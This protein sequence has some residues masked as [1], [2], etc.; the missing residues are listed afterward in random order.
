MLLESK[1]NDHK[2]EDVAL[3]EDRKEHCLRPR[4]DHESHVMN[5]RTFI[6][7][8]GLSLMVSLMTC[9][10][11]FA[12]GKGYD[13]E[14]MRLIYAVLHKIR[15]RYVDPTRVS[16]P[17]MLKEALSHI[18]RQVP[19][20]I[21]RDLGKGIVEIQVD[22]AR[23]KFDIGSVNS[24]WSLTDRLKKILAFIQKNLRAETKRKHVEY[25][26]VDGM[27]DT[28][29]PHSV[30]MRPEF[31]RHMQIS[32]SGHFGGLGIE[33]SICDGELTIRRPLKHTP[34]WKTRLKVGAEMVRAQ[35]MDEAAKLVVSSRGVHLVSLPSDHQS[36]MLKQGEQ[37]VRLMAGDKIVRIENE[38]TVNMTLNDAVNRLRGKPGTDVVIWIMRKGWKR[39][40]PF[41]IRRAEIKIP[42]VRSQMLSGSIAYVRLLKFQAETAMELLTTLGKMRSKTRLNGLIMDL[43]DNHG[44]L[45]DQAVHVADMFVD[46]GTLVS[47]VG[48]AGSQRRE[49]RARMHKSLRELSRLPMVVLVNG[50]S[51]SA[52]EIVAAALK[53]LDRA[54][55]LGKNTF[56]KG[57]VQVIFKTPSSTGLKLTISQ[58]FAPNNFSIQQVGLVPDIRTLPVR[59]EAGKP[60]KYFTVEKDLRRESDLKASLRSGAMV[61]K[62]KPYQTMHYL[63]EPVPPKA[64]GF[65]CRF[66]GQE[67]DD[68]PLP[69]PDVF[70]E[71]V[72]IRLAKGLLQASPK[73]RRTEMLKGAQGYFQGANGRQASIIAARFSK[74][75]IDWSAGTRPSARPKLETSCV[76]GRNGRVTSGERL[77]VTCKVSNN[78]P[79]PV[80]RLRAETTSSHPMLRNQEL[81][82]GAILPQQ[83]KQAAFSVRIPKSFPAQADTLTIKF[84]DG[85]GHAPAPLTMMVYMD[86]LESPRFAYSYKLVEGA[87]SNGDGLIQVGEE[88][89]M[90]LVVRNIGKGPARQAYA[91]LANRSGDAL[92]VNKGRFALSG[93]RTNER[94]SFVFSFIVR[95][96]PLNGLA[97]INVNVRDCIMRNHVGE[98]MVLKVWPASTRLSSLGGTASVGS[99]PASGWV[100]LRLC[101]D[102]NCTEVA[103][104]MPNSVFRITGT[105]NGW[106]RVKV[107]DR[108][109][110]MPI[111]AVTVKTRSTR[112]KPVIRT[113]WEVI[114]PQINVFNPP[115]V[116]SASHVVLR[117]Q[118][119]HSVK[120]DDLFVRVSNSKAKIYEQK[121]FYASNRGGSDP[122][123]LSFSARVPLVAGKNIVEV[124]ARENDRVTATSVIVIL[125]K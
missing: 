15:T 118:A 7:L 115:R 42:S 22:A 58:W 50:E 40:L 38:S 27:L 124:V 73:A 32:T 65:V 28:L 69:N 95:A 43:R 54:V 74:L 109:A 34:A 31:F 35:P 61:A 110:F 71:D 107:A 104:A 14:K 12:Q 26:A 122:R 55:I 76:A 102:A 79:Y 25:A 101:P 16:P 36:L 100:S 89:R 4:C 9:S 13:L 80:Y 18:Q 72:E 67:P 63:T 45:L 66:C 5:K 116:A 111:S 114:P 83:S 60:M 81:F 125:R 90:K 123:R 112:S 120:I 47:T 117:G 10:P 96:M 46:S 33:I 68:E 113:L 29:D 98:K 57:S 59:L 92:Y 19:E 105:L 30:L 86:S 48:F 41:A 64:R 23:K 88:V 44:G 20:V 99:K 85:F 51:A 91:Y 70:V 2:L 17:K 37:V 93:L 6:S 39:A 11:T 24:P 77:V 52:S 8:V 49:I 97:R 121:V 75:G 94:K 53:N 108:H 84:F 62:T 87:R 56:G 119:H 106:L 3:P 103:R 1:N 78:S 82:F 21:V